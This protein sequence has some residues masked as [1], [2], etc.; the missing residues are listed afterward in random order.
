MGFLYLLE[1]SLVVYMKKVEKIIIFFIGVVALL[2]TLRNWYF[3]KRDKDITGDGH[4]VSLL[5]CKSGMNEIFGSGIDSI[6]MCKCLL[7]KFYQLIKDDPDKVDHFKEVGFFK[8]EGEANDSA[9]LMLRNCVLSNLLDTNSKIK[10]S[11]YFKASI[12]NRVKDQLDRE[13]QLN[14]K[15]F[16]AYIKCVFE[17]M[18]GRITIKEYF[19][20][21]Y[22]KNDKIQE[23]IRNCTLLHIKPSK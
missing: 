7:P 2:G 5:P 1:I 16:E 15:Q 23:I 19:A 8:L 17:N 10:L 14:A 9:I 12:V 13:R 3:E 21:D 22:T 6:G 18:D 20:E 4:Q 11:Q